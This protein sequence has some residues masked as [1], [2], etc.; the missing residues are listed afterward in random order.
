MI[1]KKCLKLKSK[2]YPVS[3]CTWSH[4]IQMM[5]H[6]LAKVTFIKQTHSYLH[7]SLMDFPFLLESRV[8]CVC[9]GHVIVLTALSTGGAQ[10]SCKMWMILGIYEFSP[11][12]EETFLSS[13]RHPL[14]RK[15]KSS[16]YTAIRY[17]WAH[18][19]RMCYCHF[20]A[21]KE[22]VSGNSWLSNRDAWRNARLYSLP[23]V[24]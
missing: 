15:E 13:F 1:L 9:E 14:R 5:P 10:N 22:L 8:L 2:S 4:K 6:H 20:T 19:I 18:I 24:I 12:K 11:W 7:F 21:V 3:F 23:P 16:V 17:L